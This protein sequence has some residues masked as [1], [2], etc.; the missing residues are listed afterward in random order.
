MNVCLCICVHVSGVVRRQQARL[1]S[2]LPSCG[3]SALSARTCYLVGHHVTR[4]PSLYSS[5]GTTELKGQKDVILGS[6]A[7]RAVSCFI[8]VIKRDSGVQYNDVLIIKSS[9]TVFLVKSLR[10]RKRLSDSL[11]AV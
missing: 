5:K 11:L 8:T 3:L 2:L 4:S 7:R 10:K 6:L 9:K 1:D